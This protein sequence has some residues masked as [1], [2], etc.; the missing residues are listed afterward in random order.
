MGHSGCHFGNPIFSW[1][2]GALRNSGPVMAIYGEGGKWDEEKPGAIGPGASH[3]SDLEESCWLP[4][5]EARRSR[6]ASCRDSEKRW[7]REVINMRLYYTR[8]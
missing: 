6:P 4:D 5:M 8:Q 2:Q 1:L 7:R 3:I